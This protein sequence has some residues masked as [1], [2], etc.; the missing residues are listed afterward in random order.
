LP[1]RAV[2]NPAF[3]GKPWGL[4]TKP[5]KQT[6]SGGAAGWMVW[7]SPAPEVRNSGRKQ[8]QGKQ[9]PPQRG[10]FED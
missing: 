8:N 2:K 5:H 10:G 6:L 9:K 1:A 4:K 3:D 7:Y